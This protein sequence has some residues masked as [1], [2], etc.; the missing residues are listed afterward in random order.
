M[1]AIINHFNFNQVK[2][3]NRVGLHPQLVAYDL[4][5]S[6]GARVGFN[7]DTTVGPGEQRTYT[8]YAGENSIDT[9]GQIVATPIEFGATGLRDMGDV[10]KHASHGATGM[11]IIEPAGSNWVSDFTFTNG[12]GFNASANVFLGGSSTVHFREH[13][14]NYQDDLSVQ[15]NGVPLKNIG[16]EDDAEDTGFKAFNYRSEPLWAR[17]G[18][19]VTDV[20]DKLNDVDLK[21]VL[22]STQS[23][24]GC[25]NY[26]CGDPETM[27]FTA[28]AGTPTRFRVIQG[29]GHPRQHGFTIFGHHWQ[30]EPWTA[31]STA[32]GFNP[33]TFEVGSYSGIGPT[34][35]DN[36]LTTAGGLFSRPGDYLYR[37]QES[38]Q[39]TNGLW[40]IFRVSPR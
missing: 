28:Y 18:L 15:Q 16:G 8:W 32:Q 6:D 2:T 31:N 1:P 40:G 30:F 38:F 21:N 3:S 35:H 13:A 36:I 5:T 26:P 19:Q 10:I 25:N 33:F 12:S 22:S 7:P 23:N 34:R 37:T 11:L 39:F 14:V 17:M 27:V 9:N 29:A 20:P 24:P 4:A